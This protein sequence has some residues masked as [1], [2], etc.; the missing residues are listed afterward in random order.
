MR[1]FAK[2]KVQVGSDGVLSKRAAISMLE[3]HK[4]DLSETTIRALKRPLIM[5]RAAERKLRPRTFAK[6]MGAVQ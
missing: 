1:A 6:T 5:G 2:S 3:I 4:I